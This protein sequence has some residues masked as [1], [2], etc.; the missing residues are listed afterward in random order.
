MPAR[1]HTPELR[2]P[3][4][5]HDIRQWLVLGLDPSLTRTGY[6]ALLLSQKAD[7]SLLDRWLSI[8]SLKPEDTGVPVWVRSKLIALAVKNI[9]SGIL[10]A[11]D[12]VLGD[13]GLIISMEAPTPR[14]DFLVTLS[15]ILHVVLTEGSMPLIFFPDVYF[16]MTNAS[17]LRSLMGLTQRGVKNKKENIQ[18]AY[19]FIKE[20]EFPSLDSDACDAVLMA[21]MGRE[22]ATILLGKPDMVPDRIRTALCNGTQKTVG[23]GRNARQRTEGIFHRKEYWAPYSPQ[24]YTVLLKNAATRTARLSRSSFAI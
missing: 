21:V 20:S 17:T 4:Q 11:F 13:T 3:E 9:I 18:K 6:A 23:K 8:G 7:G 24:E 2:L 5:Q 19:T 14:N 10:T 1:R 15:R 16:Q 22:A 12:G